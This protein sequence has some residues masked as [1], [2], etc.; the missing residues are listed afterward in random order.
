MKE[1]LISE[2]VEPYLRKEWLFLSIQ[3]FAKWPLQAR[4]LRQCP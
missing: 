2:R 1:S 4:K 3:D